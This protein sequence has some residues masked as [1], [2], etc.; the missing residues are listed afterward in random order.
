MEEEKL[1]EPKE[2]EITDQVANKTNVYIIS[3][4]PAFYARTILLQYVPI[5]MLNIVKDEKKVEEMILKLLNYVAVKKDNRVIRLSTIALI[6]NHCPSLETVLQL[7]ALMIDYN[8]SFFQNGKGLTILQKLE[9]LATEKIT[10]ILTTL[11][12]RLLQKK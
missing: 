7:E 8:T 6:N 4:I 3:K 1:L 5:Q 10:G 12:D 2:V 9:A 11:S